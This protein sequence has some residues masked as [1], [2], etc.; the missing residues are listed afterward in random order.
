ME[1]EVN[2]A[3]I[4]D[5]LDKCSGKIGCFRCGLEGFQNCTHTLDPK[6]AA[7]GPCEDPWNHPERFNLLTTDAD[8]FTRYWE[9]DV[10]IH[11]Y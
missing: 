5:G 10:E 7:N 9:G 6:H 8:I 3:Y 2:V 4:C 1:A 11:G